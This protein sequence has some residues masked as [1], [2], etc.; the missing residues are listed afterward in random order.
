MVEF[1]RKE[2]LVLRA[3]SDNSRATI[4]ELTKIAGC[5]RATVSKIMRMLEEDLQLRYT[6]EFDEHM[7]SRERHVLVIKLMERPDVKVLERTFADEPCVQD[8]FLTEGDFDLIVYTVTN[9]AV[10]YIR[11]ETRTAAALAEYKAVLKPSEFVV[12]HFGYLP[13]GD[14]FIDSIE[15]SSKV[16]ERDKRILKLLNQDSRM[17]YNELSK[18]TGLNED[19]IRYRLFGLKKRGVIRR[20]TVAA[21]RP[22]RDYILAFFA[23]YIFDS[24]V[25]ERNK[26]AKSS[27]LSYDRDLPVLNTFQLL[28][29]LSGSERFFALSLF[30]DKEEADK[31]LVNHERIF[32]KGNVMVIRARVVKVLKGMFSFRSLDMESNYTKVMVQQ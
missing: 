13:L 11:W 24:Q 3:L 9:N 19:T 21:Q 2:R 32:G 4:T 20:F 25:V 23:N 14:A 15:E 1:G 16:D 12:A 22:N 10:D 18:R 28:A 31:V 7:V 26:L 5:S 30:A 29:P 6:L 8:A 27:Y 17:G